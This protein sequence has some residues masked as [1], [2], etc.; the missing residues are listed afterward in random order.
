MSYIALLLI[1][2]VAFTIRVLPLR[3]EIQSGMVRLGEF[4][5]YFYYSLTYQMVHNGLLSPFWPTHWITFQQNYPW[6]LD[7]SQALPVLPFVGATLYDIIS[8]LGANVDLMTFCSILPAILGTLSV[9]V[10]YFVGKDMGGKTVGLLAA[11][12][13]ALD[14]SVIDRNNLGWYET[15]AVGVLGLL[16]FT[17]FFLKAIDTSKPLESSIK[18]SLAAGLAIAFFC[19]GWGASYY[20]LGL[21]AIFAFVMILLRRNS[22]HLLLSYGIAFGLG[23]FLCINMPYLGLRYVLTVPVLAVAG[24]FV[25]LC[26][27]ELWHTTIQTKDKTAFAA[28]V[29]ACMVGGFTLLWL[30][31]NLTAIAGKFWSTLNPFARSSSPILESVAEHQITAWG[32]I[33]AE[34]GITILFLLAG[35]YFTL[36]NPTDRNVFLVLFGLTS[37]YF[38]SSMVR[39]LVILAPAF[40]L[41][42]AIGI[43]GILKPFYTLL[44][45]AP[46]IAAKAKRGMARVSK[47][48]SGIAVFLI[49]F[50]LVTNF[51]FSPQTGGVPR[52][53]ADAYV[54]LTITSA[55]LPVAPDEP[56]PQW[57]NMLSW[58]QNNLES[59]TVV[60]AWWDYGEWLSVLGNV[61]TLADN[62]TVNTTQIENIGFIFM[63]NETQSLKM[64]AQY[65]ATYI[66]VFTTLV[67]GTSS[68]TGYYV[69]SP[70]GY[71]DEGKWF[72][73]ARISGEARDR[74]IQ[75]GF[76][77]A[78]DSWTDE[79]AFGSTVN[80]T[81]VWND[82]GTN[83][84]IYKLMSWAKQ[85]WCD[86][87]GGGYVQPDQPGVQPEYFDEA[88][89]SGLDV[90]PSQ[91]GG[92]IPI[93]A[94]YKI[95]W[96]AYYNATNATG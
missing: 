18:Y 46:R 25:L 64:L 48:Y 86:V 66:L 57:I 93:V 24:V 88:Y 8:F 45:E 40:G 4:D 43:L 70:A 16:L 12:F 55:S 17:L 37:L 83:S 72:W 60:V 3:W 31:G 75:E 44:K 61:T 69:A 33:Y 78:N 96:Q 87:S 94:L 36:R 81:W 47:E 79:T 38:A 35:L 27:T 2:F 71:G 91:Y 85:R 59:T 68:T 9:L 7:M 58:L 32:Q 10:L 82:M 74:F 92:I 89:F 90:S 54:P 76:I 19:G 34:F 42:A 23:F 41:L 50:I 11:L 20:L 14:P 95:D 6:G 80:G 15:E 52:V 49:F 5:S 56:V 67:I 30:S 62:T 26:L 63:A 21:V 53:Y 22:H 29:L 39:L 51:A 65:N 73:M 13:L 84:T 77:D 28:I 1:L